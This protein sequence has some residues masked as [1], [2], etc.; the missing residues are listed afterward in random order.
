MSR[1]DHMAF[2]YSAGSSDIFVAHANKYTAEQVV[3]MCL[4]EY[5]YKFKGTYGHG[6]CARALREPNVYDVQDGFCAFRFGNP[7]YP[8]GC[9]TFVGEN[10]RGAFP[11]YVIDFDT[12]KTEVLHNE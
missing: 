6:R 7:E 5:E 12:L 9:Y 4:T 11:V 1:F 10:E 2:G 3:K 8:D